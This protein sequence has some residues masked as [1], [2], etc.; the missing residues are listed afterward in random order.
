MTSYIL[1]EVF[2]KHLKKSCFPDCWKDSLVV[3]L[4]KNF[5]ETSK[6]KKCHHV[7]LLPATGN[8]MKNRIADHLKKCG[9]FSDFQYVFRSFLIN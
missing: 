1:G 8:I 3:P 6:A 5:G 7:T 4:F 9:L 2:I